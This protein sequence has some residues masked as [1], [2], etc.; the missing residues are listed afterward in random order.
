ME[1]KEK[2]KQGLQQELN[3]VKYRHNMLGIMEVKLLQMKQLAEQA[4]QGNL[5][6]LELEKLI[7]KLNNLASQ[8]NVLDEGSKLQYIRYNR[9]DSIKKL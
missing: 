2:L 8:V 6:A 9:I 5:T 7:I 4:K 3:L 1:E